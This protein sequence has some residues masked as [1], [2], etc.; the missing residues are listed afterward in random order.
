MKPFTILG[1]ILI[2][3]DD[4]R[5]RRLLTAL[6]SLQ[7]HECLLASSGKQA[8]DV[9]RLTPPDIILL[10]LVM[11]EMDGFEV[12]RILKSNQ[13]TRCI[14]I[15]M[16]TSL[17][18][19]D[20]RIRG[21]QA[22][23]EDF[24]SKPFDRIELQMR[25]R[26]LLKLKVAM[27]AMTDRNNFLDNEI[28]ERSAQLI[29]SYQEAIATLTRAAT[30]KDEET[31]EHVTRIGLYARVLAQAMGMDD[32]FCRCIEFASQLH[33]VGKIA[34]PDRILC[35]T[36]SFDAQE[37]E[38]MK[39]HAEL[40]RQML[41][42]TTSPYLMM[43]AEIAGYHHERWDGGGYPAGVRGEAI[44]IAARIMSVCDQYDALRSIRPYKSGFTHE[45]TLEIILKGDGRTSP[46]HFDPMVLDAF[47]QCVD[48]FRDIYAAHGS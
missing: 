27:D 42:G 17:N 39:T 45:H 40:G 13:A 41:D 1:K 15:I 48:Q 26:N 30:Y 12:A 23:A 4:E 6:L 47:K 16:L 43:G 11:P 10:D 9:V 35:K 34:I 28:F 5:N 25:I 3:D 38:V 2:I 21:L 37:W 24:V 14:P 18:D 7:G 22:G 36:S 33:D 29:S 20:S 8:L 32:D 46:A 31:G 44:P 19:A